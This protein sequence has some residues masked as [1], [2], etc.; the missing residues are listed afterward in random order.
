[1]DSTDGNGNRQRKNLGDLIA[2]AR[3]KWPFIFADLVQELSE[4][5]D[6]APEQVPCPVC[7]G[8]TRFRLFEDYQETGGSICNSCGPQRDGFFTYALVKRCAVR[9][10]VRDIAR[11]LRGEERVPTLHRRAPPPRTRRRMT[12]EEVRV[13][14]TRT[15]EA[16]TPIRGTPAERY[17]LNRGIWP[18]HLPDTLLFH[19]RLRYSSR[20]DDPNLRYYDEL[21]QRFYDYFPALVIPFSSISGELVALQR[22]YLT[23]DGRKAPVFEPKKTTSRTKFLCGC[24]MQL[25]K[26]HQILGVGEGTE[27]LLAVECVTGM[28]VWPAGN[29]RLLETMEIPQSVEHVV[30]WEDKDVSG[31]GQQAGETLANTLAQQGR[32]FERQSPRYDIPEGDKSVGW[33]DVLLKYGPEGFPAKWR[34]ASA[35]T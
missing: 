14:L 8:V 21:N 23:E 4:A 17:L 28:P 13:M 5:V 18:G 15:L 31:R 1:L 3:G 9:D 34:S 25:F 19:P 29:A 6:A 2:E 7:G 22:Y 20:K 35:V 11:W 26:P 24:A 16:C 12:P 32:S 33:L 27:N 10:A 30:I